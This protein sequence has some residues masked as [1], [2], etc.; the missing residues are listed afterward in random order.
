MYDKDSSQRLDSPE[1]EL[2]F[3]F[4]E[5]AVGV[6]DS[7]LDEAAEVAFGEWG[8]IF[9]LELFDLDRGYG[10]SVLILKTL[11]IFPLLRLLNF[12]L[13]PLGVKELVPT[14]YFPHIVK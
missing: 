11:R 12:H 6:D 2:G 13:L 3:H 8:E 5:G 9:E 1:L 10:D 4:A 14:I 7:G